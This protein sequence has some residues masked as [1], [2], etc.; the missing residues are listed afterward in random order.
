MRRNSLLGFA[1]IRFGSGVIIGDVACHHAGS[2]LWASPP[3]MPWVKAGQLVIDEATGKPKYF[4]IIS[5]ETHGV[6]RA[7]SQQVLRAIRSEYPEALPAT[8][9]DSDSME[10]AE[11][12]QWQRRERGAA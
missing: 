7:W 2:R 3:S 4:P 12:L 1:K 11:A 6:Q 5:F 8:E 10:A 9:D